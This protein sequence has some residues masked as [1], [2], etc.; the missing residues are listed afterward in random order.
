MAPTASAT[1]QRAGRALRVGIV[2]PSGYLPD[3]ATLDRAAQVFAARGWQVQAGESCFARHER[4]AGPDELRAAELQRFCTDPALDLLLAARGG[5]GLTRL[6]HRLDFAAI[7]AAARPICGYSDFTAFNLAYLARAG[8]VSLHGPSATDFGA[9]A[10]EAATIDGFFD[11]L[12]QLRAGQGFAAAFDADGPACDVTGTLWGGNLALITAL[13]GTPYFPRVRGGILFVED[14]NEPAYKIER[15]LIQLEQA[16]VLARQ[17]ALLLGRFEPVAAMP[18][19]NGF[20][21]ASVVAGLRERLSLPVIDGL[22]FGHV[23]CKLTLPV[24]KRVRLLVN[25]TTATLSARGGL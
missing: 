12:A 25:G 20:S 11:T 8:G 19:D 14:V 7:R 2:A 22:P 16:G 3:E 24:G 21:L 5:Y 17:R 4:F 13:L 18:N 15:M 9:A 6:L 23:P 1:R 10:P